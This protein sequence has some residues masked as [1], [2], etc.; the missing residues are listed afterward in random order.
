MTKPHEEE[1]ELDGDGDVRRLNK[2]GTRTALVFVRAA[3]SNESRIRLAS[4]A[5]KRARA[6]MELLEEDGHIEACGNGGEDPEDCSPKC[7][8]LRALLYEAGV[9]E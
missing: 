1:W 4:K 6:L 9:L 3:G 2:K 8:Q 5:P 7:F